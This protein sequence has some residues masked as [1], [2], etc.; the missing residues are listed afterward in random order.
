MLRLFLLRHSKAAPPG[1][2][3]DFERELTQRG[4]ADAAQ[5]GAMIAALSPQPQIVLHSGA[6]RTEET[7]AIALRSLPAGVLLKKE[8]LI[9]EASPMTL[10]WIV[11]NLPHERACALLIGHN[12]GI[13]EFA[14]MLSGGGD[15]RAQAQMARKYPTSGLAIIDFNLDHWSDVASGAGI[16]TAFLTPAGA[17]ERER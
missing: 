13:A 7:A 10:A 12:P 4:R 15:F 11:R 5:V 17:A 2:R 14:L 6:A 1:G 9:Y 16:L 8:P 3:D